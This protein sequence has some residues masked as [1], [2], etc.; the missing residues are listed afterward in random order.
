MARNYLTGLIAG[1]ASALLFASI[2]SGSPLSLVLCL[3]AP[4]PIMIVGLGWTHRA[5]LVAAISASILLGFGLS[6]GGFDLRL[7]LVFLASTALPAWLLSYLTLLGRS[8]AGG[9]IVEWF[10]VGSIVAVTAIVSAAITMLI[11]LS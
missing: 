5:G 11:A 2:L 10:P 9:A 1:L 8:E 7:F 3:A 4:L 6:D